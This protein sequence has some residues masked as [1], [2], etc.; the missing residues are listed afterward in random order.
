MQHGG[1]QVLYVQSFAQGDP[2]APLDFALT[3]QGLYAA[4]KK[5][6]EERT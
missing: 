4:V 3:A 1:S 5:K 6:A 2:Y